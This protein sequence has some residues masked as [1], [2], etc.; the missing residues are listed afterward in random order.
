[1]KRLSNKLLIE[2]YVKAKELNLDQEFRQI[3]EQEI[4]RRGLLITQSTKN[5]S[6]K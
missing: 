4:S 1:M 2:S 5:E 6:H 3:I